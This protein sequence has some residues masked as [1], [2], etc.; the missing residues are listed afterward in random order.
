MPGHTADCEHRVEPCAS[1]CGAAVR[2]AAADRHNCV[3]A[4]RVLLD[5]AVAAV[6][7][8]QSRVEGEADRL[9]PVPLTRVSPPLCVFFSS[10][11][12]PHARLA[13]K[14]L[15]SVV[16][17]QAT[18]IRQLREVTSL[19]SRRVDGTFDLLAGSV[20]AT[21][22]GA[23]LGRAAGHANGR[24]QGSGTDVAWDDDV[25]AVIVDD[26][27]PERSSSNSRAATS[28][29]GDNGGNGATLIDLVES[30]ANREREEAPLIPWIPATR[31]AP[32]PGFD[33]ESDSPLPVWPAH[34]GSWGDDF[35]PLSVPDSGA[36][37]R[38]TSSSVSSYGRVHA[39][40]D[41]LAFGPASDDE[42]PV[43]VL[44]DEDPFADD[45]SHRIDN[46]DDIDGPGG[47]LAV[48]ASDDQFALIQS[49]LTE[50]F[51]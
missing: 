32:F 27:G 1:G 19:N 17:A 37:A 39:D 46:T 31:A 20:Q 11:L 29:G 14:D 30:V 49:T 5:E 8:L 15:E 48:V 2:V 33:R 25:W 18:E 38:S 3:A 13:L 23:A 22:S 42:E 43:E 40:V 21:G 34:D 16:E 4:M 45:G 51:G 26:D 28:G 24:S 36:T 10:L 7:G 47:P 9:P 35:E 50:V 12:L 44:A 41:I 6:S